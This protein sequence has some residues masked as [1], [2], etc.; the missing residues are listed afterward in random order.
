MQRKALVALV[1]AG[2]TNTDGNLVITLTTAPGSTLLS[3]LQRVRVITTSPATTHESTRTA[4][5]IDLAFEFDGTD[6]P[7]S[8]Y[9]EGYAADDALLAV[10]ESPPF[11]LNA[12]DAAV[13]IFVAPPLS[14]TASPEM[15]LTARADVAVT[16]LAYGA[17]LAGGRDAAGE[18][19][20]SMALYNAY[21]HSL[22][23][24]M[25]MP[26]HRSGQTLA[27]LGTGT[28]FL[29][30][31]TGPD[32]S[33]TASLHA[34]FSQVAPSGAYAEQ[35]DQAGLE[36][37]HQIAIPFG[38]QTFLVTGAPAAN[39][40]GGAVAA[41]T[42]VPTLLPSGASI[43]IEN[44]LFAAALRADADGFADA[45]A[46]VGSATSATVIPLPTPLDRA[47]L[48]AQPDGTLVVVGGGRTAATIASPTA[49]TTTERAD[50]LSVPRFAPTVASTTRYLVVAGGVDAA[51]TPFDTADIFDAVTL[52][53]VATVPITPRAAAVA[54]VLPNEQVMFVGGRE[55]SALLELFT[56]PLP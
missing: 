41:R 26:V 6:T 56:P 5:G 39:L 1:V 20:A 37:T 55:P 50:F 53:R 40:S 24:A 11:A 19:S 38:S 8:I 10:G 22:T 47:A 54:V 13:K 34:F 18:L 3:E 15:L 27:G 14:V 4:R 36:R 31:G 21:N 9:I 12:T 51:N 35:G 45:I 7:G 17:A 29:F 44:M 28:V 48:V 16:P 2:C 23:T 46:V 30:G 43:V 33:P 49:R 42:D 52:E 32:G 25:A